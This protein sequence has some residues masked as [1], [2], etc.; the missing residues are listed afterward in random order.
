MSEHKETALERACQDDMIFIT[1]QRYGGGWVAFIA[2]ADFGQT[3]QGWLTGGDDDYEVAHGMLFGWNG[4]A[5][6]DDTPIKAL[7][8][9][10]RVLG[11]LNVGE[12]WRDIYNARVRCMQRIFN[13]DGD[14]RALHKAYRELEGFDRPLSLLKTSKSGR[15]AEFVKEI[16]AI[17][18]P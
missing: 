14:W 1:K 5:A 11:G 15:V 9:L 17:A 3:I 10:S 12:G 16:D 6:A 13:L 2:P 18:Q 4:Q 7:A 8:Y